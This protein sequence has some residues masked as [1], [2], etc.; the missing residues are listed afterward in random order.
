M[1]KKLT[2]QEIFEEISQLKKELED[3]TKVVDLVEEEIGKGEIYQLLVFAESRA[4]K[5]YK[6]AT[7]KEYMV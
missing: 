6:A 5:R 3:A 7:E 4:E 1:E 2:G